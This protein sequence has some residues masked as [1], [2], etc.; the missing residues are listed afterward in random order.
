MWLEK[1]NVVV[2]SEVDDDLLSFVPDSLAEDP[3][4]S[5]DESAK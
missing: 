2:D 5:T 1:N 3:N 4:F